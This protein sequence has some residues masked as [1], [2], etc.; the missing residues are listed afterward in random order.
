[1]SHRW[2]MIQNLHLPEEHTAEWAKGSFI[3]EGAK[4]PSHS[5]SGLQDDTA[6]QGI[7]G[8]GKFLFKII[9]GI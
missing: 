7:L 9:F 2:R 5:T 6:Q 4:V 8:A 3:S 1:M